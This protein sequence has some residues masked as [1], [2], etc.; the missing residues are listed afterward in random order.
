M[1]GW[2]LRKTHAWVLRKTQFV[3]YSFMRRLELHTGNLR[4]THAFKSGYYEKVHGLRS[5][6]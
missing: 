4:K 2:V 6:A 1:L 5:G 3:V